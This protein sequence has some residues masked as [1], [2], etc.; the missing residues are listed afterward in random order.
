M[1]VAYY[2][3][4]PESS[5][6]PEGLSFLLADVSRLL[7]REIAQRLEGSELTFVQARVLVHLARD[8]GLRQ[9][10]LAAWLEVQP[11]TLARVIDQL[12]RRGLV[13]RRPD[14]DDRRA[15]RVF[16]TSRARRPLASILRIGTSVRA[17]ALTGVAPARVEA[18]LHALAQMRQNLVDSAG[19]TPAGKRAG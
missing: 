1:S 5:P 11:I 12:E 13:Q 7:R 15:W 17:Q 14:P 4:P 18:L 9:V 10:E 8:P 2:M 6:S 3:R 16:V 19:T